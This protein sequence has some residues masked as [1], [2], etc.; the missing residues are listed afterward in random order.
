[1]YNSQKKI[2]TFDLFGKKIVVILPPYR[3]RDEDYQKPKEVLEKSGTRVTAAS[4]SLL[5]ARG[6]LGAV[7]AADVLIE[8]VRVFSQSSFFP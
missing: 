6:M 7:V 3:F 8:D 1:M 4:S 2:E 5:P